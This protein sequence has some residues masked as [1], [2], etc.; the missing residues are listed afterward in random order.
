MPKNWILKVNPEVWDVWEWWEEGDDELE[1]WTI[2][3]RVEDVRRGDRFA[4]WISGAEAGV[5]A[6]GR[7]NSAPAGPVRPSGGYWLQPPTRDTWAVGLR[8]DHYLF[9]APILKSTLI[10]D[11]AFASSLIVRAPISPNPVPLSEA[12]WS[13]ITARIPSRS[14]RNRPGPDAS[15]ITMRKLG[16]VPEHIT[17]NGSATQQTRE[18]REARLL[19]RYE[20]FVGRPLQTVSALLPSGER[21]VCDA[22]D[23]RTKRLIEA[24]A[25]ATRQDVR[26]AIGQLLDYRRHMAPGARLTVLLPTEPSTDVQDLLASVKINI[27]VPDGKKFREL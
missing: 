26:M 20:K 22:F 21:L 19:K 13:T 25:S 4:F 15:K 24:K 27:I 8:V 11:P 3:T 1:D 9:G 16:E 23:H 6:T 17:T 5:Y 18:F 2:S 7:I 12:E 10:K 14:P